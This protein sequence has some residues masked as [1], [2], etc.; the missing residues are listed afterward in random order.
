MSVWQYNV[1]CLSNF[2]FCLREFGRAD[3]DDIHLNRADV[4]DIH[5]NSTILST[6][7]VLSLLSCTQSPIGVAVGAIAGHCVA[8]A[9]A[10]LGGAIVAQ[11]ISERTISLL[12]GVCFLAFA[13]LGLLNLGGG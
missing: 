5:L 6:D 13:A 9:I 2:L 8:T 12:S 11:Y 10:V 3:V 1:Q 7:N 4:D